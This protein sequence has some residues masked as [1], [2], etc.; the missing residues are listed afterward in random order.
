MR[1]MIK[2]KRIY[3]PPASGD[4]KRILIDRLWPRGLKKEDAKIDEWLRELAPSTELR[5]WFG[6]DPEK[7]VEFKRRFFSELRGRRD[8]ADNIAKAARK[9]T[10]T[11]LFA[12]KEERFN[13]AAAVKEFIETGAGASEKKKAS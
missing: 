5:K 10:V 11:L 6:H 12:S 2:I 3:D 9:G 13:N 4:G 1:E 7:W 8:L